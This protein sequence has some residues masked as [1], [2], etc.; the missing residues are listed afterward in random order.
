[1][2]TLS[3]WVGRQVFTVNN[4]VAA[5]TISASFFWIFATCQMK[6]AFWINLIFPQTN[7]IGLLSTS[8]FYFDL[9]PFNMEK[10]ESLHVLMRIDFSV[11]QLEMSKVHMWYEC[12]NDI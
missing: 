11:F 8:S 5:H 10:M 6:D 1:M 7:Y 12:C 9:Q 4:Y 2:H 3:V